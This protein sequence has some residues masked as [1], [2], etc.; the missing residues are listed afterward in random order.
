MKKLAEVTKKRVLNARNGVIAYVVIFVLMVLGVLTFQFH[1]VA[2]QSMFFAHQFLLS[3]QA[4]QVA[5]VAYEEAFSY[6]WKE[7]ANPSSPAGKW[8]IDGT[9]L[10]FPNLDLSTVIPNTQKN[11]DSLVRTYL[12]PEVLINAKVIDFRNTNSQKIPCPYYGK[13]GVGTLELAIDVTLKNRGSGAKETYCHLIRHHDFKIVSITSN[14]SSRLNSYAHN[15][16]LDYVFFIRQGFREFSETGAQILNPPKVQ[17]TVSQPSSN[18]RGSLYFGG[19]TSAG[20]SVY[21]NVSEASK[22]AG[23]IP[24]F[25][26]NA[27]KRIGRDECLNLFPKIKEKCD[28]DTLNALQGLE[29]VFYA[30]T[31]PLIK[32]LQA[33][34]LGSIEDMTFRSL[35]D[36]TQG[37]YRN[38]CPGLEILSDDPKLA[39][40]PD[41][42]KSCL[43]GFIRQRFFYFAAFFMDTSKL[44]SQV[45][46]QLKGYTPWYPCLLDPLPQEPAKP[47]PEMIDFWNQM[48]NQYGSDKNLFSRFDSDYPFLGGQTFGNPLP[49]PVFPIPHFFDVSGKPIFDDSESFQAFN[50]V[51]LW[52][53][54]FTDAES[55]EQ[56]GIIDKTNGVINLRGFV[57]VGNSD[58][59]SQDKQIQIELGDPNRPYKIRGRGGILAKGGSFKIL[60]SL[61][62][63]SPG[64]VFVVFSRYG[65]IDISTD[66]PV[67]AALIA[68]GGGKKTGGF[69]TSRKKLDLKG[70]IAAEW[71]DSANWAPDV[72]H[73][74]AY[75]EALKG[76]DQYCINLSPSFTFQKILESK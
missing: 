21:L 1:W 66:Q 28:S 70:M 42:A 30:G 67:N 48:K 27:I 13:E 38:D 31:F 62:K 3:D 2:R 11:M 41:Y 5:E 72:S 25:P 9:S 10:N 51:N 29:G 33:P 24:S 12:Q 35:W 18:V 49:E 40:D 54:R 45:A 59:D 34:P 20:Q 75:D 55:L 16:I 6:F 63:E 32:R 76:G 14:P 4:R 71:F 39:C 17:M 61:V 26:W 52:S 46:D 44:D 60:G 68:L 65:N 22:F 36:A 58:N 15:S 7:T 64:D 73:H 47:P 50:H 23:I 57:W 56:A 8:L 53:N 19:T 43:Q 74:I 69:I 37:A